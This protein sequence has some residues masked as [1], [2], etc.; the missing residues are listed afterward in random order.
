MFICI[1]VVYPGQ[2]ISL[3]IYLCKYL[4]WLISDCII[5]SALHKIFVI[6][7]VCAVL[8]YLLRFNDIRLLYSGGV[9]L[10]FLN[11]V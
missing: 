4:I 5:Y 1:Q 7:D 6:S 10:L 9:L 3:S 8:V 11:M 2:I